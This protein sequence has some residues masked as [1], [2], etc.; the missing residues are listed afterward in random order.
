MGL[1]YYE[2]GGFTTVVNSLGKGL[3]AKGIDVTVAARIVRIN[4]PSYLNLIKLKPQE[5]AE[6]AK[7]YDVIHLHTTYPYLEALLK[8][9]YDRIIFTYH[10]YTPWYIVP[11]LRKKF[12]HLYLRLVYK[13]LLRK[14]PI[15]TA[16]SNFAKK[17][18]KELYGVEAEVIQN[19]VDTSKFKRIEI[20]EKPGYPIIFNAAAWNKQKGIDTLVYNFKLIK[21][22]YPDAV[23]YIIGPL[24][25]DTWTE[26][27]FKDVVQKTEG[28]YI[29]PHMSQEQ[30]VYYYNLADFYILTSRWESFC[31]PII[32][33][34]ACGTPAIAHDVND[35]RREH[36]H[37]SGAG[38][39][40][41][42]E[43]LLQAVE[44]MLKSHETYSRRAMD[45]TKNFDWKTIAEKYIEKYIRLTS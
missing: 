44:F 33:S 13:V 4:P 25:P 21:E 1:G 40:Y 16:V 24:N 20:E 15:V 45:Y 12:I 17:Q 11:G 5:L 37:N 10:G 34:F 29:L 39:L 38:L 14:I 8:N 9:G 31:F 23:L 32:E 18:I 26:K 35:V 30:L 7:R 19:G 2:G 22:Y 43:T 36:I 42:N 41:T 27:F 3:Q 6:E 28:V